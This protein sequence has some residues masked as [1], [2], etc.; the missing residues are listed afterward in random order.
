MRFTVSE[1]CPGVI[2]TED[3]LVYEVQSGSRKTV[4]HRV[5]MT[6]Y[7]GFGSCSCERFTIAFNPML[8]A[9]TKPTV[10]YECKHIAKV[11]R[12]QA[13]E[14]AQ[15]IIENRTAQADKVRAAQGMPKSKY[16]P[17]SPA[18]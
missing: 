14:M 13:I 10:E 12:Y 18:F 1:L 9:G 8:R 15:R 17:E 7:H 3:S 6:A 16:D 2:P 4:H 5:D 11:R